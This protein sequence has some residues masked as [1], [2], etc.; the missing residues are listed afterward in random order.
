LKDGTK[1]L[2]DE[3]KTGDNKKTL[4]NVIKSTE[5]DE[6]D[7]ILGGKNQEEIKKA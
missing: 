2:K 1:E 5:Y 6:N 4:R 3:I 7:E